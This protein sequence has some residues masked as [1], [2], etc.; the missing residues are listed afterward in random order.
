MARQSLWIGH[1]GKLSAIEFYLSVTIAPGRQIKSVNTRLYRLLLIEVFLVAFPAS[2]ITSRDLPVCNQCKLRGNNPPC[3]YA[4]KRRKVTVLVDGSIRANPTGLK[5]EEAE[6][7]LSRM[8]SAAGPSS[9]AQHLPITGYSRVLDSRSGA[10]VSNATPLYS[11][12]RHSAPNETIALTST[13]N[14]WKAMT[15]NAPSAKV[16][17]WF[18]LSFVS[19]PATI[20]NKVSTMNAFDMPDR[21]AFE[22]KLTDFLSTLVPEMAETACLSTST[23]AAI[24]RSLLSGEAHG[25]SSRML[26]WVNCHRLLPGSTQKYLLVKPRDILTPP[27]PVEEAQLLQEYQSRID[28][29]MTEITPGQQNHIFDR[30]IVREQFYDV[31]AYAHRDHASSYEMTDEIV[32]LAITGVS[33]P[34][35]DIFVG[36]C[37][38]CSSSSRKRTRSNGSSTGVGA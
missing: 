27:G 35:A 15:I 14:E 22:S 8:S 17:P 3:E 21:V 31:L 18:H 32:Q 10:S 38:L 11:S 28:R 4:S 26:I 20:R 5:D 30:L 6:P 25:L 13:N 2:K 33:W 37:P 36:L 19:L 9:S 7:S 12:H 29:D 23:Y 34:M 1:R 24:N 16:Q